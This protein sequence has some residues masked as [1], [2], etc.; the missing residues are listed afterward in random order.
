MLVAVLEA[1]FD[2]T[3]AVGEVCIV[4][5]FYAVVVTAVL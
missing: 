1:A 4:V 3:F 5:V 2:A